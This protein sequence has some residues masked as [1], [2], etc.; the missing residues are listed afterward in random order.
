M[1][2][3]K[4]EAF[5]LM[6][7]LE[8]DQEILRETLSEY[9][10]EKLVPRREELDR[11]KK[12]PHWFYKDMVE[13]GVTAMIIPEA[14]GGLGA[15]LFDVGLIIEE[16]GRGCSGA[17]TSLGATFLG[18]DPLL[19][20]GTDEQKKR[21][22][23]RIVDGEIAAFALTEP[24]AGSDAAGVKT[25]AEKK[26][27]GVYALKGQK[28]YITNGGVASIYTVF[29]STDKSRGPRGVS[30]FVF[31][32]DPETTTPGLAFPAKFDKMGINA[33]ETRE[34]IF[35]GFEIPAENLIGGKE[36]RGFLH[37]MGTFDA[38][39]PMIGIIGVG[40]ARAAMEEAHKY[41]HERLQFGVPVIRFRGLQE[42]FVDMV[43]TVEAA[44]ALC[45]KVS[46]RLDDKAKQQDITGLSGIAKVA[47]SEAGRVTLDA[48]QATGGY[49]YMNETPFPKLVRD[50]KIFE[51]FEGTNQI[52]REQISLQLIKEFGKGGWADHEIEEANKAHSRSPL[53]GA[54]TVSR[55]RQVFSTYLDHLLSKGEGKITS[56]QYLRFILADILIDLETAHAFSISVSRIEE[57]D[58]NDFYNLSA[59]ISTCE[60][61]LR[62]AAR[63]RR[64]VLGTGGAQALEA[65][66]DKVPLS[67]IE[68]PAHALLEDRKTLGALLAENPL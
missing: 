63:L 48:L 32:V 11:E 38:T 51:I 62:G 16:I 5:R 25:V 58:P 14:Y 41:T 2:R 9:V 26:D 52:Q 30:G 6:Y 44:R 47:G 42:M 37:T 17:A 35:D 40:I 68:E 34:I 53:C 1:A 24:D 39:R 13:M 19:Y 8:E 46:R 23:P 56:D 22:L 59:R 20:F 7:Y 54:K 21:F 12:F 4:K 67:S 31:E 50:F 66:E 29:A 55:F 27:G 15:G 61:A 28:T 10:D 45:L 43:T 3:S 65:L 18:I 64:L 60:A 33:S 49:G 36:G 57:I